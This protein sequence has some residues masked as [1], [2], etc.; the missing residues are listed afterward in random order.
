MGL[1]FVTVGAYSTAGC[2]AY[3]DGN[4]KGEV[5]YGTSGGPD[6]KK[7]TL[8]GAKYRPAGYD[9]ETIT[10]ILS[11]DGDGMLSSLKPINL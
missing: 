7:T 6:A 8:S 3:N 5:Y 11:L 4:Y 1:D 10:T 2:Y 9:C